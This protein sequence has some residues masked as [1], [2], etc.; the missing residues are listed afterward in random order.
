M[1]STMS[2]TGDLGGVKPRRS[3]SLNLDLGLTVSRETTTL[4]FEELR[5]VV[6]EAVREELVAQLPKVQEVKGRSAH[7]DETKPIGPGIALPATEQLKA[8]DLRLEL[9]LGKLPE[10]SGLLIDMNTTAKLLGISRRALERMVAA[11]DILMPIRIAGRIP[12]WRLAELLEW[13]EA[14]CPHPSHWSYST[15]PSVRGKVLK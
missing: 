3:S 7:H 1:S 2:D 8:K 15:N 11:Q 5:R 14:G 4:F 9:L 13:I 12:R 6:K 10:N